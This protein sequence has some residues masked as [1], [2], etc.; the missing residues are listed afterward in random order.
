MS[1]I[2]STLRS[3]RVEIAWGLFAAANVLV[4]VTL[5]RWETIPFHFVWVSLTIV[6]GFRTWRLGSTLVVLAVVMAVTTWA[7]SVTVTHGSEHPD[8][9]TEVPLMAAMFLA[10]VWHARRRQAAIEETRR[11]AE[12]EHRLAEGQREFIRDA[13]HELR[14]PITIARGHAELARDAGLEPRAR[15]DVEVVIDELRRLSRLSE[16]LLL[17]AAAEHPGFLSVGRVDVGS[18]IA[19]V[20]RRWRGAADRSWSFMVRDPG[21][22]RLD[23]ERFELAL[24]AVIENALDVT[25]DGDPIRIEARGEGSELIVEVADGGPGIPEDQVDRIFDRFTRADA[26]RARGGGGTGLGLPIA[27][28]IARAH[29]GDLTVERS[30]TGRDGTTMRF[31]LPGFEATIARTPK[32][33][34]LTG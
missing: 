19:A 18:V 24:D 34:A 29:G 6:Y 27:R 21:T 32:A 22:V 5:T 10:M 20:E 12:H 26:D 9:L 31:A 25:G 7:L 17:L 8:E 14:T 23:R 3:R 1:G 13:S 33:A 15:E 2:G 4:I 28:A 30:T 16:R 11:L